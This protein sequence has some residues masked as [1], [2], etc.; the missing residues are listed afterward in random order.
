MPEPAHYILSLD[1]GLKR[2]GVAIAQLGQMHAKPLKSLSVNHGKLD[3]DTLDKLYKEWQPELF[4]IGN[5]NTDN[6]HLNKT[7]RRIKHHIQSVYKT[8]VEDIDEHLTTEMANIE[9]RDYD[10]SMQDKKERRDQIAACLI[11][12]TYLNHIAK[13]K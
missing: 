10:L 3:F 9:M 8:A 7:I 6:P 4:V 5:P 1:V 2:T 13:P 12:E 11:L